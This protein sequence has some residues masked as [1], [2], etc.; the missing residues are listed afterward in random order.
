MHK[1]T[2]DSWK[3]I[4]NV[5]NNDSRK[6][7]TIREISIDG[8]HFDESDE[9]ATTLINYFTNIGQKLANKVDPVPGSYL[10]YIKASVDNIMYVIPTTPDEILKIYSILKS[11]Q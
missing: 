7:S 5:I 2:I 8:I 3:E 10:V 6:F 4:K 11:E 9:I 1:E